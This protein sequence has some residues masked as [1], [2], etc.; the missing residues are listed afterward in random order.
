MEIKLRDLITEIQERCDLIHRELL[1]PLAPAI[2]CIALHPTVPHILEHQQDHL[3]SSAV[4]GGQ[5]RV[6]I[7]VARRKFQVHL[8]GIGEDVVPTQFMHPVC[9]VAIHPLVVPEW[10]RGGE[11]FDKETVCRK[12]ERCRESGP[13]RKG[14][15]YSTLSTDQ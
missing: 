5:F 6:T 1:A 13:S 3:H 14:D 7:E 4:V 12:K 9:S 15:E 8:E 2:R 11:G 10:G